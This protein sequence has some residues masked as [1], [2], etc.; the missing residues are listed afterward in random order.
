MDR[1]RIVEALEELAALSELTGENP[2]KAKAYANAAR[3]LHKASVP[4]EE[5]T[6]PGVLEAIQGVGKGTAERVRELLATG[7]MAD[8]E[9]LKAKVPAGVRDI[10]SVPGLGPKKV[11]SLWNQLGVASL[12][13]L[14]YACIE[15]RLVTLPG[16]GAKTQEKILAG[17][18]FRARHAG[19]MLLPAA[20]AA[21]ASLS[22]A[23]DRAAGGEAWLWSGEAERLCPVATGLEVVAAPD[24][25][26]DGASA[27]GLAEVA[28]GLYEGRTGDGVP[29]TI[30]A[31]PGHC[32]GSA[33]VWFSSSA[34]FRE[35]L[36]ARL[37]AAGLSWGPEGLLRGGAAI[38]TLDEGSFWQ[39]LG[40]PPVPAECRELPEALDVD[41]S[42]LVAESDIRGTVHVHTD[43]SDGGATLEEM[44]DAAERLG[45]EYLG[46]CDH[47]KTAVYA[48]GLDAS[49]LQAQRVAMA[50]V[51]ARHPSVRLFAGV[52]SDILA[53][54]ALD[55]P[56]EVLST[57]DLVVASVHSRFSLDAEAQT[58]R[59]VN[60]VSHPAT[61]FLGHPT[62]RLLLS[63]EP[64]AHHW[65]AVAAAAAAAGCAMEL[66]ANPHR[67]DVDWTRLPA[68]RAAG[69]P[70][71]IHPDAHSVAGLQ[72]VRYGVWAAR[73]ALA[74]KADV[75]NTMGREEYAQYLTARKGRR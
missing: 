19:K 58:A 17:V 69:V 31:V 12:G 55:Y 8:L 26:S 60:A 37:A 72:D 9:A 6:G 33:A 46:I 18:R 41:L 4:E 68:L 62:G 25:A 35:V 59:L 40:R 51:Q 43:W 11:G 15:N 21:R 45:W 5:W 66:N 28:G 70:I 65:E 61:T 75:L 73:K 57:L 54:G 1:D 36:A 67:L 27:L 22:A 38:E 20:L 44:T 63:R 56:D 39:A 52:E 74:R 23:F 48:G 34:P 16:F 14:E 7:S 30:R 53:E 10:L 13:E 49:R 2:F 71:G 64:Y 42:A 47:S 3:V 50:E 32:M 24:A 29:L